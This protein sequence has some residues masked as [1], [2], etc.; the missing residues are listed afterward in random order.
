M[1]ADLLR[2]YSDIVDSWSVDDYAHDG[3]HLRLKASVVFQNG[4]VLHIRQT[5]IDECMFKYAYHWQ[6]AHGEL[7]CRW[8]NAPHWETISTHPHHAH[9]CPNEAPVADTAGGDLAMVL[10]VI[11]SKIRTVS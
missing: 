4:S 8:D 1:L 9:I 5:V 2:Q 10:S 7:I 6:D 3:P 11:A